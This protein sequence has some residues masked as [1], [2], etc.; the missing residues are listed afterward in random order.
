MYGQS[1]NPRGYAP[2]PISPVSLGGR[3][4]Q[5]DGQK[6]AALGA[7]SCGSGGSGV[8]EPPT[9][10]AVITQQMVVAGWSAVTAEHRH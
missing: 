9:V 5:A 8:P 2:D 10:S 1:S 4:R 7:D 6:R 3:L